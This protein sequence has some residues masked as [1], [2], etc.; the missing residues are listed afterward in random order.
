VQ[1]D[2]ANLHAARADFFQQFRREMQA[3]RWRG[4]GTGGLRVNG[5]IALLIFRQ[6]A[7]AFDV[8]R[9]RQ[10]AQRGEF[11]EQIRR[12][13]KLQAALALGVHVGHGGNYFARAAIFFLQL[14]LG[15]D[16]RAFAGAHH[17]PPVIR[18]IFFEQQNFKFSAGFLIHAVQTRRDDA[19]I[20]QHQNI[21]GFQEFQQVGKLAMRNF[22][23]FPLQ[24]EQPRAVAA[25]GGLLRNQLWRQFEMEIGGSHHRSVMERGGG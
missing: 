15:S 3:R 19:R 16:G 9:Q 22:P 18:R 24:N 20:V 13:G 11:I 10:F 4:H 1:R 17:R 12:A 21:A 7:V 8:R 5:L 14:D 23:S 25:R 2:E 6:F